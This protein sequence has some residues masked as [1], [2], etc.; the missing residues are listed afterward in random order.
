MYNDDYDEPEPPEQPR[1]RCGAMLSFRPT[2]V[3]KEQV[4]HPR[5]TTRY[6]PIPETVGKVVIEIPDSL[7]YEMDT[8]EYNEIWEQ[9]GYDIEDVLILVWHCN[10]CGKDNEGIM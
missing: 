1:C 4:Q 9:D 7:P 3:K 2:S 5:W 6:E 8:T 10:R